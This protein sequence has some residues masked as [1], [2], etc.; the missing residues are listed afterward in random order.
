MPYSCCASS[1][2]ASRRAGLRENTRT[3]LALLRVESADSW[4]GAWVLVPMMAAT[5]AVGEAKASTATAPMAPVCRGPSSLPKPMAR[6]S[7]EL[8]SWTTMSWLPDFAVNVSEDQ[9][10]GN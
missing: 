2:K 7:P 4:V 1:A 3:S 8:S 10:S 5:V 9:K 6:T